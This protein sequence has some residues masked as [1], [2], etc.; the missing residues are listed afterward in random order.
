VPEFNCGRAGDGIKPIC[1]SWYNISATLTRM[2]GNLGA[3]GH[4]EAF[5]GTW[6]IKDSETFVRR[7]CC[8]VTDSS[9]TVSREVCKV[10]CEIDLKIA[11][12]RRAASLSC[13]E[14]CGTCCESRQVEATILEVL[15]LAAAIYARREDQ[16]VWLAI[17]DKGARGELSCVLYREDREIP[18]NGRCTYYR[19]RPLLCRLFGFAARRNRWGELE[20]CPCRHMKERSPEVV[21]RAGIGLL[22]GLAVPVYQESFMR[23]A[24]LDPYMGYRRHPINLAIQ[25][26]LGHLYW[27]RPGQLRWA[28][29]A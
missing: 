19:F 24:C 4:E 16:A 17:E 5:P 3:V 21:R 1:K 26:A 20:F 9:R 22:S 15:P 29:A 23:I 27:H 7:L 10:Y 2:I 25:S 18:G 12:L 14:G 11:R 13:P 28:R 6:P 8:A